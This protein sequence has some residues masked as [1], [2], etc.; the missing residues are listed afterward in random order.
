MIDNLLDKYFK[1][2]WLFDRMLVFIF[3]CIFGILTYTYP[4]K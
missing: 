2:H 1:G 4:W 3:G